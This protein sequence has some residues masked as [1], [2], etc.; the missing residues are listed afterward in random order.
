MQPFPAMDV[1]LAIPSSLQGKKLHLKGNEKTVFT[2]FTD[3]PMNVME[4]ICYKIINSLHRLIKSQ[5]HQ[6]I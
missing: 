5:M 4:G 6:V 1:W 3:Q 2:I